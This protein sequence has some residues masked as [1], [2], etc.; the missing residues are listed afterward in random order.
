MKFCGTDA[1]LLMHTNDFPQQMGSYRLA[2]AN[3]D[4]WG[5]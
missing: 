4:Y 2:M 5:F 3:E 1:M